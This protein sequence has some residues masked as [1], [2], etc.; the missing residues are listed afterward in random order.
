MTEERL[1]LVSNFAKYYDA[2][3]N[4]FCFYSADLHKI[5]FREQMKALLVCLVCSLLVHLTSSSSK[6]N[7]ILFLV[8]DLGIGD[9]P[10]FGKIPVLFSFFHFPSP[11]P[12]FLSM[13]FS[14]A[15]SALFSPSIFLVL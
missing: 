2:E 10:C 13:S 6:P 14:L 15:F 9:V 12:F 3:R 8:D 5:S 7:I 11:F 1:L 4:F